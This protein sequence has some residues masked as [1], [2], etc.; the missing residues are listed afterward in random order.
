MAFHVEKTLYALACTLVK[1]GG[2][3]G[4]LL[5]NELDK[6]RDEFQFFRPFKSKQQGLQQFA[7]IVTAPVAAVI[8]V[9]EAAVITVI[10]AIKTMV[11]LVFNQDECSEDI[12]V[13]MVGLGMGILALGC[14]IASPLINAVNWVGSA[15]NTL[16]SSDADDANDSVLANSS[17]N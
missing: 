7:S 17:F 11:D 4:E 5:L 15:Y 16:T 2:C 13:A 3:T 12:H 1:A 10:Y 6:A 9:F 8:F 14:I